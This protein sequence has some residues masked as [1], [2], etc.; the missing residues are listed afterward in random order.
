MYGIFKLFYIQDIMKGQR[1]IFADCSLLSDVPIINS[2]VD[3]NYKFIHGI[4]IKM[5]KYK[6]IKHILAKCFSWLF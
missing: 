5:H 2:V 4:E 6:L 3:Y 1:K